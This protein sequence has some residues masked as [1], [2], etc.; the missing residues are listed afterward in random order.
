MN[1]PDGFLA[2]AATG[3]G[4]WNGWH[5]GYRP[6]RAINSFPASDFSRDM[7]LTSVGANKSPVGCVC[8]EPAEESPG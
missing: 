4:V 3:D 7:P 1:A 6:F 5:G 8:R 2:G